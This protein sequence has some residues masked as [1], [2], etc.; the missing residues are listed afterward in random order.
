[1]SADVGSLI[2]NRLPKQALKLVCRYPAKLLTSAVLVDN[3]ESVVGISHGFG[4]DIACLRC[5]SP[6]TIGIVCPSAVSSWV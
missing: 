3:S 5:S 6:R 2:P 4:A 1:M